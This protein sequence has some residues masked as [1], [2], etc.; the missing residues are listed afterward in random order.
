LYALLDADDQDHRQAAKALA[1]LE[2]S[3]LI[4]HSFVVV[5]TS[6]LV[7]A[8]LG[9]PALRSLHDRLLAPL[10]IVWVD[11]PLHDTALAALL[12]AGRRHVS[13]V[14]W[15]SFELMRKRGIETALAFDPDFADQGFAL[16]PE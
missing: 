7:Q 12:G 15:V 4:T 5:E 9:L 16:L 2:G 6:A 3:E 13:L 11:E 8:R 14:D 10:T 1:G